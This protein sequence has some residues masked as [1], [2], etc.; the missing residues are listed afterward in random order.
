MIFSSGC[1][2]LDQVE[3]LR[4]FGVPARF[5]IA[6]RLENAEQDLHVALEVFDQLRNEE[7]G[8]QPA[9]TSFQRPFVLGINKRSLLRKSLRCEGECPHPRPSPGG[10]GSKSLTPG[11]SPGGRGELVAASSSSEANRS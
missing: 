5:P 8:G 2:R 1:L 6:A 4:Q 10:E 11:P 9:E 3:E 7:A